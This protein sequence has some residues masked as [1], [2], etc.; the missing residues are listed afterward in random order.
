MSRRERRQRQRQRHQ[1]QIQDQY[2]IPF[3]LCWIPQSLLNVGDSQ[4]IWFIIKIPC[5][6]F[7]LLGFM[8]SDPSVLDNSYQFRVY[9]QV[10]SLSQG[11]WW[12][13]AFVTH[14]RAHRICVQ[15]QDLSSQ[16]VGSISEYSVPSGRLPEELEVTLIP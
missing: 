3:R 13:Y 14:I 15:R 16:D 1:H 5:A 4:D 10:K 12:I 11:D 6:T 9:F 8:E 7:H 2:E